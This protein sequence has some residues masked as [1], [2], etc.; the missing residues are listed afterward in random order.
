MVEK[1]KWEIVL[2]RHRSVLMC[3]SPSICYHLF[4]C[5]LWLLF[6]R[7]CVGVF[8][9]LGVFFHVLLILSE[10]CQDFPRCL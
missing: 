6:V 5:D 10:N 8:L 9:C 7:V 1:E 4:V 3:L 2:H